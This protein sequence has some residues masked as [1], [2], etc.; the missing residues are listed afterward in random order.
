MNSL[1]QV[2]EEWIAKK[3]DQRIEALST[4]AHF[5]SGLKEWES[6]VEACDDLDQRVEDIFDGHDPT[7]Y[8][9]EDWLTD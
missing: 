3:I 4:S 2:F 9:D 5:V 7:D 6:V 1:L 8:L